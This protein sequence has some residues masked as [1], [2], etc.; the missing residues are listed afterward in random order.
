MK[1]E[2]HQFDAVLRMEFRRMFRDPLNVKILIV[3]PGVIAFSL[4]PYTLSPLLPALIGAFLI[5]EPRLA[6]FLFSSPREGEALFLLTPAWRQIVAAK[7]LSAGAY[8]VAAFLILA[9]PANYFSPAPASPREWGVTFCAL[10]AVLFPLFHLANR[11]AIEHPRRRF[12]WSIGDLAEAILFLVSVCLSALPFLL[13]AALDIPVLGSLI[14]IPF[15]ALFW[16]RVSIP[17]TGA[18]LA[19]PEILEGA[20]E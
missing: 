7:N 8:V 17:R 1:S 9:I 13:V 4:W 3:L 11:H 10:T 5:A 2:L 18:K 12:T 19:N 14:F 15:A 16:L 6:N 20:E